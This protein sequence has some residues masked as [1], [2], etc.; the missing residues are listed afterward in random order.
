LE[1]WVAAVA[2]ILVKNIS[3]CSVCALP[4]LP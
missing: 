1:K 4:W 2:T 3:P